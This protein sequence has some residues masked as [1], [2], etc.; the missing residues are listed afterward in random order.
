[1]KDD[2]VFDV[3]VGEYYAILIGARYHRVIYHS[4]YNKFTN[5]TNTDLFF[6]DNDLVDVESYHPFTSNTYN[7]GAFDTE[8]LSK[9]AMQYQ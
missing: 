5:T 3:Y 6:Y 7:Q 2:E 1:M 9:V 4:I 8:P